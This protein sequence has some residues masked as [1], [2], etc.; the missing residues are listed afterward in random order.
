[1]FSNRIMSFVVLFVMAL[2]VHC[3]AELLTKGGDFSIDDHIVSTSFFHWYTA[4][5]GQK[6]GPCRALEGRENWTG[7]V[8]WWKGQVKQTMLANI[9]ILYVHLISQMDEQMDK[10][11][12]P[13]NLHWI[14]GS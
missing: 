11:H 14:T 6:V 13:L 10:V 4:D 9:D 1:M 5:A 8:Q 3:Q 7:S 12:S 2:T